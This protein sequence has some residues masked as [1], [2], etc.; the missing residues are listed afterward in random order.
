MNATT[1]VENLIT[2]CEML[3]VSRAQDIA[4]T[5]EPLRGKCA[6]ELSAA[7]ESAALSKAVGIDTAPLVADCAALLGLTAAVQRVYSESRRS[8]WQSDSLGQARAHEF[9]DLLARRTSLQALLS[10][11]LREAKSGM[12]AGQLRARF[13][14][15]VV[16]TGQLFFASLEASLAAGQSANVVELTKWSNERLSAPAFKQLTGSILK[17]LAA[18]PAH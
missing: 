3:D 6:N 18:S 1:A 10:E 15:V 13:E 11:I 14:A 7:S 16:A 8:Y 4:S 12:A 17:G 5:I 2:A 9:V